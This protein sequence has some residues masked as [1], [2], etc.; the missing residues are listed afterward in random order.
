M[1]IF[2][3]C[4]RNARWK[5][6]KSTE[7]VFHSGLRWVLNHVK[8]SKSTNWEMETHFPTM[9]RHSER[10]THVMSVYADGNFLGSL[11]L[12]R[13]QLI[14]AY[15]TWTERK[16]TTYPVNLC[17]PLSVF[18][19]CHA[20]CCQGNDLFSFR[21]VMCTSLTFNYIPCYGML[22]VSPSFDR[23]SSSAPT[24]WWKRTKFPFVSIF[25]NFP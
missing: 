22:P 23:N 14:M 19:T 15:I 4:L 7:K 21:F 20:A 9:S 2:G 17:I 13:I 25:V 5:C 10:W 6:H 11:N 24:T 12:L 8:K 18:W 16:I 1:H 3:F